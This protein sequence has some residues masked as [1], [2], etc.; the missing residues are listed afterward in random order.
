MQSPL[1]AHGWALSK[2]RLLSRFA[3]CSKRRSRRF[4]IDTGIMNADIIGWLSSFT[5]LVTIAKQIHGQWKK[6]T[7]KGVSVYLFIGQI[8][9]SLGFLV[10]SVLTNSLVFIV[11]NALLMVSAAIGLGIVFMHRRR[12]ASG[13]ERARGAGAASFGSAPRTLV[14]RAG[15]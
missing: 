3:R 6:G 15:I 7:S 13:S 8:A 10:Y 4:G 14:G 9:A 11:T 2:R 1:L 5:L 12:A